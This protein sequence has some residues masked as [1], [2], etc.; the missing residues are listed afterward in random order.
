MGANTHGQHCLPSPTGQ[1]LLSRALPLLSRLAS[2]LVE[3]KITVACHASLTDVLVLWAISTTSLKSSQQMSCY[4]SHNPTSQACQT[5]TGAAWNQR[6]ATMAN[7]FID[8]Q[9]QHCFLLQDSRDSK[10]LG[11]FKGI[12]LSTLILSVTVPAFLSLGNPSYT[13]GLAPLRSH[14]GAG[15]H[16]T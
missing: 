14:R 1:C 9:G 13:K 2:F 12:H 5:C 11:Y 7:H 10:K 8:C 16:V 4:T 3:G 15:R 6:E